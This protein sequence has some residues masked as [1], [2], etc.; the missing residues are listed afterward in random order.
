MYYLYIMVML[1]V[2]LSRGERSIG[3][4]GMITV[5]V[6]IAMAINLV[7]L[8]LRPYSTRLKYIALVSL[9]MI[10]WVIS[11]AYEQDFAS[12]IGI[13]STRRLYSFL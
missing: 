4:C 3:Y 7:I 5:M 9:C 13:F 10:S 8:K 12:L 11:Y 1:G 6:A 2:S